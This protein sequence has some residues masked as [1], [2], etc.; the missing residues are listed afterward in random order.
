V[1]DPE[2]I[3]TIDDDAVWELGLPYWPD[4]HEGT[5]PVLLHGL[6]G[7]IDA[8]SVAQVAAA[9][10]ESSFESTRIAT[11][12]MDQLL[13]YRSKRA[14]MTFDSDRWT[15]YE[16]PFLAVDYV[17]DNEGTGFLLL[18]GSEPDVQW[19]RV[20]AA[21]RRIIERFGVSLTVG[22]HGIPM[23]V[24]H[25]RPLTL[26]AHGTRAGL[27]EDYTS[28]FGKIKVPSSLPALLEYRLGESGHDA[29]GFTIHVPHYLSQ[30]Q[31]PPAA[32]VALEH[33]ERATGLDLKLD[34]LERDGMDI[35]A[36]IESEVAGSP[37]VSAIV[38]ALEEQFDRFTERVGA[39]GRILEADG[40][41]PTA[42]ELA[43][44][45]EKF[46]AQ[47]SGEE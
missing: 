37:E 30:M 28:F 39:P 42:D 7:F 17:R 40:P 21:V 43:A 19:E 26:T 44:E 10:V 2:T 3:V 27:T 1:R 36:A 6:R 8:G 16:E 32:K 23:G 22:F 11:F 12:D 35:T 38:H 46:L 14:L 47:E 9:H 24:P 13:D 25:T 31:Y 18:Y 29:M 33:V 34:V 4:P 41:I 20:I 15:D 5:G 45:F